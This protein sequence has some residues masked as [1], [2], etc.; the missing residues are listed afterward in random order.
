[1]Q[2]DSDSKI[3]ILLDRDFIFIEEFSSLLE[4]SFGTNKRGKSNEF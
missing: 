4:E 1:M 3:T 2:Q